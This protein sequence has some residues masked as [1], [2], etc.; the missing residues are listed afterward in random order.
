MAPPAA[1]DSLTA[2]A[3]PAVSQQK[4]RKRKTDD[5]ESEEKPRGR[6]RKNSKDESAA[7]VCI[8]LMRE[9]VVGAA[10]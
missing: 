8:R 7:E 4:P 2:T 5:V 10:H 9:T 6:P 3:V 1:V